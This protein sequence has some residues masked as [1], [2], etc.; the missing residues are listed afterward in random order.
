MA[1]QKPGPGPGPGPGGRLNDTRALQR[2]GIPPPRGAWEPNESPSA[3]A[4]VSILRPSG[5]VRGGAGADRP[6]AESSNSLEAAKC[7]LDRK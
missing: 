6:S 7:Y 5:R 2:V 1:Y 4:A 3:E